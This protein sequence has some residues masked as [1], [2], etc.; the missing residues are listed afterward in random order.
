LP[1]FPTV[2]VAGLPVWR[3]STEELCDLIDQWSAKGEGHWIATLNL[4]YYARGV[5]E[6][7]FLELLRQADVFT[8]DGM[9]ILR[10]CQKIDSRFEGLMRTTG[11]DL[12]PMVLKKVDP[13]RIAVV[14]GADPKKAIET[15][16]KNPADFFIF[17]GKVELTE[18]WA[19]SLADQ[20]K[21]RTVIFVALGCPKQEQMIALLKPHM[22]QAVFV[23]VGGSF[24]MLAGVTSRAPLW[25]Q[26]A[27]MEWF[28]RLAIEPKRLWRRYLVEYPPGARALKR[29]TLDQLKG[30][31]GASHG[32]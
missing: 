19:Q 1:E 16:G 15:V 29:E 22:P 13:K 6:P 21:D 14:G 12:T 31:N 25:M 5:R 28:Y 8:A 7:Q 27:G 26:K 2:K 9:P 3:V 4:D 18:P 20:M 11:A 24:D 23:A 10:A 32:G 30:L 17:D